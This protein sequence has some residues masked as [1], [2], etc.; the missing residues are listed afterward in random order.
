[1]SAS[2]DPLEWPNEPVY[3]PCPPYPSC[4]HC[5]G[6]IDQTGAALEWPFLD[7]AYCISLKT[8]DDRA[9]QAAA[10]FHKVGCVSGSPSADRT[11]TRTRASSAAGHRTA[12]LPWTRC[13][14]AARAPSSV[15]SQARR[16][17]RHTRSCRQPTRCSPMLAIQRVS[18]GDNFDSARKSMRKKRLKHLVTRSAHREVLL[19]KGAALEVD[20]RLRDPRGPVLAGFFLA[21][22]ISPRSAL[23]Q[24]R[25]AQKTAARL[26][27]VGE[28]PEILVR[29]PIIVARL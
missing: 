25:G 10:E 27:V 16:S 11:T 13:D 21:G 2:P 3:H 24:N 5:N 28:L 19:S 12:T 4:P 9:A 1:M 17:T 6:P 15:G 7:A 26:T 14:V 22:R 18:P 23:A 20:A 29:A 8:R